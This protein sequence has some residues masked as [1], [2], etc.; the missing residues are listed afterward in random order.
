MLERLADVP[1][2]QRLLLY[3][4]VVALFVLLYASFFLMPTVTEHRKKR[5]RIAILTSQLSA[6]SRADEDVERSRQ[7]VAEFEARFRR[8]VAELPEKKEI[9]DLL[10]AVSTLGRESG[11]D[12]L[13]FRQADERYRELYAEVPVQMT[14]RGEYHQVALFFDK[15]RRLHRIVNISDISLSEPQPVDGRM[16]LRAS[17][18]AT[19]FRFLTAE[20]R[21]RLAKEKK[22][23][24]KKGRKKRKK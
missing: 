3:G 18:S 19:T 1:R 5:G 4:G 24:E 10:A 22:E 11:L 8:A 9:P 14:V 2:S 20:E 12:I 7:E 17:F 13:M 15:V 16:M 6:L 23:A 21:E